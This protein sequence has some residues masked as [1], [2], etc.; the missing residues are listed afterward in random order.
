V[1]ICGIT[2]EKDLT[3]A[4]NAGADAVGFVVDVP[5]SP[6]NLTLEEAGR[7]IKQVPIFVHSVAVTVPKDIT[8][9][10]KIY[11]KL[12]PNIIQIHGST[13]ADAAMVR[14]KLQDAHLIKAVQVRTRDSL[15][16]AMEDL[17]YFDVILVDSYVKG[18]Y[19]G[20]GKVHDWE[21]SKRIKQ[22]ISPKPFILAGGLDPNNVKDA[23]RIVKPYAVDVSTGVESRQGI[24]DPR[25]V[26]AF[27]K[28]CRGL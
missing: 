16:V 11:E 20:T 4:V 2:R 17:E 5:T 28:A 21:L 9:L 27:V 6:R 10:I 18:K 13:F 8:A 22:H 26:G 24:K 19:G 15:D 14:S 12:K 23:I 3:V 7:L 25:K 1:K